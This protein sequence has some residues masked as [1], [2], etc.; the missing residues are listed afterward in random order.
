MNKSHYKAGDL[1]FKEGDPSD[2]AY[3]IHSGRVEILKHSPKGEVRLAVL[4]PDDV[5][6]EMG[7]LEE[8]PRSASARAYEDV[9]A[10]SV[11]HG[12]FVELITGEPKEGMALLRA[13]FER[14]RTMNQLVVEHQ[15]LSESRMVAVPVAMPDLKIF[16]ATA[17]TRA[18]LPDDGLLV[19][20]FP[21]RIG[22]EPSGNESAALAFNDLAVKDQE[23][24]SV[25]LNHCALDLD[26]EGVVVRDRG[27]RDSTRV[28]GVKIGARS[29]RHVA[30]LNKGRNDL[31]LGSPDSPF[32]FKLVL[33]G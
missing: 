22:R 20:R 23:P 3:I 19:S 5:L 18:V 12:E 25:S 11:D 2:F 33:E 27:S 13:L 24:F 26:S 16:G 28:N 17:E 30:R 7:L 6:G 15:L 9:I 4:G 29:F 32:R 10:S 1:I 31:I 8:R 21:F 14:L